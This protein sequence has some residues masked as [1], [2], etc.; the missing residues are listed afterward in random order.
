MIKNLPNKWVRK[1]VFE[2]ID[3]IDVDGNIIPC[4][5]TRVSG[6][7]IPDYYFIMNAQTNEVDKANKCEYFWISTLTIDVYTRYPLPGNPGSR[8]LVDNMT[9]AARELLNDIE[10]DVA[11]DLEII[12][13]TQSFPANLD[14]ETDNEVVYRNILVLNLYLK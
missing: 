4:Y 8:L 9:D 5:D 13:K 2:L 6:A 3:G 1:A 11:S 7:Y 14:I 10:L 12:F